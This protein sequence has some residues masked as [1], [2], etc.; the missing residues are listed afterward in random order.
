MTD[1]GMT[2]ARD[3]SDGVEII[4]LEGDIDMT[5]AAL[6]REAV[7]ATTCDSVVLDLSAVTF[8][9]SMAISTLEGGQRRLASERRSL[10]V[11]CPPSTP[12]AW[13]LRVAGI[14]RDVVRESLDD[15][16]VAAIGRHT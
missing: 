13:T 11:V 9:D 15:A 5:N 2:I 16:L 6:V 10:V 8:L 3:E 7:E 4:R 14:D 12:S 1:G